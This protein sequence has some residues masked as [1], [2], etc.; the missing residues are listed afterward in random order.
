M[1]QILIQSDTPERRLILDQSEDG[2]ALAVF[3]L[4]DFLDSEEDEAVV[5]GFNLSNKAVDDSARI[6]IALALID[7]ILNRNVAESNSSA[8]G[9]VREIKRVA[10]VIQSL[11]E[12]RSVTNFN[13]QTTTSLS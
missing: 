5:K 6:S 3:D 13:T 1:T 2:T 9:N 11:M 7:P 10:A 4:D 12:L 8:S